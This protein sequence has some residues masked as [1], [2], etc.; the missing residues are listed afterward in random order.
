[1]Q[2]MS[3]IERQLKRIAVALEKSNGLLQEALCLQKQ[4]KLENDQ[5][6]KKNYIL[7]VRRMIAAGETE[8]GGFDD[9]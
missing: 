5:A 3:E 2:T 1:M 9:V 7:E 4:T 8:L 6:C